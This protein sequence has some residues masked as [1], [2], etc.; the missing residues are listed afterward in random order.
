MRDNGAM[1]LD[2]LGRLGR[3]AAA[4]LSLV[5]GAAEAADSK[6]VHTIPVRPAASACE[7]PGQDI[8]PAPPATAS[9][10]EKPNLE[11]HGHQPAM[12]ELIFSTEPTSTNK[13]PRFENKDRKDDAD[14]PP[15]LTS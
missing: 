1:S 7:M 3:V 4:A 12:D 13:V 8:S 5:P 11:W 15:A 9:D 6:S 2:K 10:K 14:C